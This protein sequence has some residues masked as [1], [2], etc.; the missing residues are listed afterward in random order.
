MK[1][2][3]ARKG[4]DDTDVITSYGSFKSFKPFLVLGYGG[5]ASFESIKGNIAGL[6]VT[7][8]A[9]VLLKNE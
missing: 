8:S 4:I 2:L 5:R 1:L 3:N 6:R 9:S 7:I